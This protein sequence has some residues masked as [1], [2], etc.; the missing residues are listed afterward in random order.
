M[1]LRF[2]IL[3]SLALH[4]GLVWLLQPDEFPI[5]DLT[6]VEVIET[7]TTPHK[8]ANTASAKQ[9]SS[10]ASAPKPSLEQSLSQDEPKPQATNGSEGQTQG[11]GNPIEAVSVGAVTEAPKV[12]KEKKIPYP[13]SARRA[14]VEGVVELKLVINTNGVVESAELVRGP[15]YGLNEAALAAIKEFVFS[16]AKIG[17]NKVPVRILYKYRFM[18]GGSS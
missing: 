9:K 2:F 6:T 13:A 10:Q 3:L 8:T 15:G 14:G 12:L 16:P 4:A 17:D 7:L 5:Q 18:L 1:K 11:N